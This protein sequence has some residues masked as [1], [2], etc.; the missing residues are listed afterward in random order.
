MCPRRLT[1]AGTCTT[2][3]SSW[4]TIETGS[5]VLE[6]QRGR[7]G[8][9]LPRPASSPEGILYQGYKEGEFPV[10]ESVAK[11]L[12]SLP[13]FPELTKAQIEYVADCIKQFMTKK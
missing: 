9:A 11:R 7:H 12:L 2:F 1:V 13:M 6:R 10:T 3:T 8:A 5:K 4:L